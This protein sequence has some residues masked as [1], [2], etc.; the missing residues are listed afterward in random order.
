MALKYRL[1]A[2]RATSAGN[3][4]TFSYTT[5]PSDAAMCLLLKTVG[6]SDRTGGVPSWGG[7][8]F[9]QANSTQKAAASPEAGTEVWYILNPPLATAT[10]TIPNTGAFTLYY[11]IAVAVGGGARFMGANGGNATST[12]PTPGAVTVTEPG[13]IG[14]ASTAGGWQSFSGSPAGVAI[15]TDDDGAHGAGTQF[16]PPAEGPNTLSWTFGTSDDWGAVSV[17]FA[18]NP[19]NV[20]ENYKKF[21][22]NAAGGFGVK[23][24]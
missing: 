12:N 19:Y 11:T 21:Q 5:L 14:F 3:P 13:G 22:V 2:A 15:S 6:A 17:Y 9:T 7:I 8:N 4:V 16:F 10:L 18:E 24:E 20:L 1:G 23:V